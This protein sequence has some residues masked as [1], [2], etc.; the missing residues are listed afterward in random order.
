MRLYRPF[1]FQRTIPDHQT[2]EGS[3]CFKVFSFPMAYHKIKRRKL[4]ISTNHIADHET[5]EGTSRPEKNLFGKSEEVS[6][7]RLS[8]P[9]CREISSLTESFQF[10]TTYLARKT[11]FKCR[12]FRTPKEGLT[13]KYFWS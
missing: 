6:S 4:L 3:G 9:D 7:V 5:T 2:T 13:H 10:S 8:I 1:A 11:H 12:P